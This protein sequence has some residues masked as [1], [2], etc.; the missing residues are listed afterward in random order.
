MEGEI[1]AKVIAKYWFQN[2]PE[3]LISE[4]QV[5]KMEP[6]TLTLPDATVRIYLPEPEDVDKG[7]TPSGK[8]RY[9]SNSF[10][11][12]IE[13]DIKSDHELD[14]LDRE[15][16]DIA[17]KYL[18][19]LRVKLSSTPIPLPERLQFLVRYKWSDSPPPVSNPHGHTSPIHI[20]VLSK[21]AGLTKN[22]WEELQKELSSLADTELWEDFI[23]DARVALRGDDFNQATIYAAIACEI[24]IKEY[25]KRNASKVGISEVFWEYLESRQPRVIDYYDSILH[26]ITCHSLKAE[27]VDL[28]RL[29]ERL[30]SARNDIVHEGKLSLSNSQTNQLKEDIKN[31]NQVISWVLSL[32]KEQKV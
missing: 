32:N 25:T 29:L 8:F 31:V 9:Y 21:Y 24:F 3:Y 30:N 6:I 19:L 14:K 12:D 2:L 22:K 5:F 26:L 20:Y 13:T 16:Q 1:M 28:Y 10:M 27:K 15:A 23:I 18:R 4:R 7:L 11:M 17:Y